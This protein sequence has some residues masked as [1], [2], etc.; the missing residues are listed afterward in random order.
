MTARE[1]H[2][3]ARKEVNQFLRNKS[4]Q[5]PDSTCHISQHDRLSFTT[6][7]FGEPTVELDPSLLRCRIVERPILGHITSLPF[8]LG[9]KLGQ[10][11]GLRRSSTRV[12]TLKQ[13]IVSSLRLLGRASGSG[14]ELPPGVGRTGDQEG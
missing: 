8:R 4:I 5:M 7:A 14:V 11:A 2:H 9:T 10:Y 13:R 12:S 6:S 1:P 3:E